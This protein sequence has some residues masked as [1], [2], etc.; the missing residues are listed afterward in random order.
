MPSP[1]FRASGVS[2]LGV[3]VVALVIAAGLALPSGEGDPKRC[4]GETR[5]TS[6]ALV[7]LAGADCAPSED[8]LRVT[9]TVR[10]LADAQ[11]FVLDRGDGEPA[12]VVWPG[13]TRPLAGPRPAVRVPDRGAG[14]A[15]GG[16]TVTSGD[17]I[18]G[19]G[20][21]LGADD[22][23]RVGGACG[24]LTGNRVLAMSRLARVTEPASGKQ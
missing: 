22:V 15:H 19:V 17:R 11:C 24:R 6:P 21:A 2:S 23:D 20:P 3:L 7:T 10:Y 4:R 13:G 14:G 1:K 18:S 5:S 16:G 8:D 9:G 12:L